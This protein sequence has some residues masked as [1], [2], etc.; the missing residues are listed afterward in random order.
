MIGEREGGLKLGL[1]VRSMQIQTQNPNPAM[2]IE[3]WLN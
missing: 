2:V 3:L 1:K